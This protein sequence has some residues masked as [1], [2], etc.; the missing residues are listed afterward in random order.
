MKHSLIRHYVNN[1]KKWDWE[2]NVWITFYYYFNDS[3]I[4]RAADCFR[5]NGYEEASAEE[6]HKENINWVSFLTKGSEVP[7]WLRKD[8][9]EI[10]CIKPYVEEYEKEKQHGL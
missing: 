2:A 1:D 4:Y 7:D 8:A 3:R 10:P 5:Q 6:V 9:E